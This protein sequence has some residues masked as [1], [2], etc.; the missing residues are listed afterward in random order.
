MVPTSSPRNVNI[1]PNPAQD[2][3]VIEINTNLFKELKVEVL[4]LL[5]QTILQK[6]FSLDPG[7]NTQQINL[8]D[9]QN[10][11]YM[12]KLQSGK[13]IFTQKLVIKR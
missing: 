5:G 11:L 10:G 8:T 3:L 6:D 9:L 2:N 13:A 7:I 4:N 12:I 1:F